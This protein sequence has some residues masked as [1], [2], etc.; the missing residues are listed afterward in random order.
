MKPAK[1]KVGDKVRILYLVHNDAVDQSRTNG[2]VV[3]MRV[4]SNTYVYLVDAPY[5]LI[6]ECLARELVLLTNGVQ[7][8]IEAL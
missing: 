1:F 2:V 6:V 4:Q 8:M 3:A 5:Y 7:L